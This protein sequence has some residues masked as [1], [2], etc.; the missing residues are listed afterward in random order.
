MIFKYNFNF[1][2]KLIQSL[3]KTKQ[4][5]I[6]DFGCGTGAWSRNDLKDKNIKKITLYDKN[7]K[8]IKILK[9]KYNYK[10]I[11]INFDLKKI[12]KKRYYNLVIMSSVIQYINHNEFRKLIK[13][14]FQNKKR[15][16]E[17]LFIIITD[18]PKLPRP[19]EFFLIPIF[20]LKR[21]V[22]ALV[23]LFNEEYKKLNFYLYKKEDFDF[24]KENFKISF[25]QNIHD[26][27][28]LRYTLI[29][30]SK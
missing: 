27:K 19:F 13:I 4:L 2:I 15:K 6:L 30:K 9:K 18:I 7:K 17:K 16:K 22:F 8:L 11:E 25:T 28:Y 12:I 5:K 24:L 26:L 3:V 14:I 29:L 10:K 20:S 1:N 21:F 23:M